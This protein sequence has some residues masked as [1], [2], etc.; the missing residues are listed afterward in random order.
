MRLVEKKPI[1]VEDVKGLSQYD[2]QQVLK[3]VHSIPGHYLRTK[4][5]FSLVTSHFDSFSVE[6]DSNNNPVFIQYLVGITPHLTTIG[7]LGD[8]NS[9][10]AGTGFIITSA[11][12][13]KRYAIYYT[14][15]GQGTPPSIEGVTNIE[16]PLEINDNAQIVALATN[17]ALESI[18]EFNVNVFNSVLEIET[19]ELGETNNTILIGGSSF[20]VQNSAGQVEA[21]EEVNLSYSDSGFPIWQG[22]ELKGHRYNIY[23]AKFETLLS[24]YTEVFGKK[25]LNVVNSEE[26][27][28]DEIITTFPDTVTELFTY[29]FQGNPVQT[30]T[31]LY[32]DNT[33]KVVLSVN[34][35]RL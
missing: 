4:D 24:D 13:E 1:L 7:V 16:V 20:L 22:Q 18:G 27:I 21:V 15:S 9:S 2:G 14:V 25:S 28:W 23:T 5:A 26:V 6:Y 34:K 17:I 32:Q 31:V 10:L 35:T 11:R 29:N 3:D 12:K 19:K 30:V 8:T 33:K